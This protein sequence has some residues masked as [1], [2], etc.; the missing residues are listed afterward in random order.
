MGQTWTGTT[1]LGDATEFS[2]YEAMTLTSNFAGKTD[3]RVPAINELNTI[4]EYATYGPAINSTVFPNTSDDVF[5][6]SSSPVAGGSVAGGSD[7]V[8]VVHSHYGNDD[9]YGKGSHFLVRLVRSGQ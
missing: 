7:S 5:W 2:Y 9:W 1:C 8:W 3:W 6:S 4:V